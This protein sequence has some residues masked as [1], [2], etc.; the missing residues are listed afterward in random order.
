MSDQRVLSIHLFGGIRLERAGEPMAPPSTHKARLLLAFLLLHSRRWHERAYLIGLLW[1]DL[2]ESVARRRLSQALWQVRD[3]FPYVVADRQSIGIDPEGAFWADVIAFQQAQRQAEQATEA[4]TL[5]ASWQEMIN[6]YRGALLPGYY[7]DWVLL[8][9][10]Q[11]RDAYLQALEGLIEHYMQFGRYQDALA[12]AKRLAA[13]EPMNEEA[14]RHVIRLY[15]LL[16][17]REDALRQYDLLSKILAE[18]LG[19]TP[20]LATEQ[21]MANIRRQAVEQSRQAHA[22]LFDETNMLPL[23]GREA[24]WAQ[25]KRM[26]DDVRQGKGGVLAISGEAGIGKTRL[27]A[28]LEQQAQW[29]GLQVWSAQA[30]QE[31]YP[32]P[33]ELWQRAI[34]PQFSPLRLEQLALEMEEVWLSVLTTIFPEIKTWLPQLSP[35]P[36]LPGEKAGQR[37]H[38]ALLHLLRAFAKRAPMVILLDDVQWADVASLDFLHSLTAVLERIP[39]LIVICYRD[40]EPGARR[41]MEAYLDALPYSS[42]R[43]RL[44]NLSPEATERLIQTALGITN[45][46]PRFRDRIYRATH[47]HPLFVLETLRALHE[48]GLLF[49]DALGK[50]STPWDESTLDYSELP[51]TDRLHEL[52]KERLAQ[53]T[54]L[55]RS[56]LQAAALITEPFTFGFLRHVLDAPPQALTRAL[57]ELL[58]YRLLVEEKRTLRLIHD[59]LREIIEE[60]LFMD[61]VREM[62]ERIA[63]A[64]L[65]QGDVSPA[66]LAQH[67]RLAGVWREAMHFHLLA[68][69]Q[70]QAISAPAIVKEHL[71]AAIELA[72]KLQWPREKRFDLLL[73]REAALDILGEREAQAR[74]LS[75]MLTLAQGDARR[76]ARALLRRAHFLT[77]TT[78]FAEAVQAAEQAKDLAVVLQDR[79][80]EL[81]SLITLSHAA[82]LWTQIDKVFEFQKQML[83]LTEQCDDP[84]MLARAHREIGDA[85]LISGRHEEAKHHLEYALH[86]YRREEDRLGEIQTL[87]LLAIQ[88]TEWGDL[89]AARELYDQELRLSEAIGYLYG[90]C[91][92]LLNT[93]NLYVLEGRYF[94]ALQ[95]YDDARIRFR[96]LQDARGEILALLNQVSVRIDLFGPEASV[97][98]DLDRALTLAKSIDER[99]SLGQGYSLLGE[100]Y[101]SKGDLALAESYLL[102]GVEMLKQAHQLW[103]VQQDLRVLCQL[104]V[105]QN[106]G[107][108]ALETL[109]QIEA[110]QEEL[111]IDQPDVMLLALRGMAYLTLG[112]LDEALH[113]AKR[114]Q[115]LLSPSIARGY[116]IAFWCA[117]IFEEAGEMQEARAMRIRAWEDLQRLLADFPE[118]LRQHSLQQKPEH[119]Q[120]AEA[121]RSLQQVIEVS[122]AHV[123]APTGRPLQEDEWVV[124]RWTVAAP[125]D[126]RI[127][128]KTDRRRHRLQRLMEEAAQQ[129][130]A[131]T[132]DDLAQALGVSRATIKRDLAALR[133]AGVPIHTRGS[134]SKG[135]KS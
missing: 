17:Q 134:I 82:L 22:P 129:Q 5:A 28:E 56:I 15:A 95:H 108:E 12:A 92:V 11:L 97:L 26:L 40:D 10:E 114:A 37:V 128:N 19:A 107:E 98:E 57:D 130:G 47:G 135:R 123:D 80:M 65:D 55:A 79:C 4:A 131:P 43:I 90:V 120:I 112:R 72:E 46:I 103:M 24:E 42:T 13:E 32:P 53:L 83:S 23:V 18:E 54:P 30:V 132:V 70:A 76:T 91:K 100:Y 59:S 38:A 50:W 93:G 89:D 101:F 77:D 119:R 71:D 6:L 44:A 104:Y 49:Q 88:A 118:A 124:V 45:P 117:Q 33:Y 16:G 84:L 9:R 125:E 75:E 66:I 115:A 74:D 48:Q 61:D 7:E 14:H 102:K 69:E 127:R 86:L 110:V 39:A 96:A 73:Q 111:R 2:P 81:E 21:L 64:Y 133:R 99:I 121:A 78:R 35:P 109:R 36:Y 31:G 94:Q 105:Q 20:G 87:H 68:A 8:Q 3:V 51:L 63:R 41:R 27:L 25:M 122:L 85:F 126:E 60:T 34:R 116:L 1:P 106:R 62:H 58:H 52:F 113:W 29:L 67:F